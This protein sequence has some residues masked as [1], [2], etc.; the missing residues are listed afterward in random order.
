MW[1]TNSRKFLTKFPTPK[2]STP[3]MT[4]RPGY[5]TMEM[6][7]GSSAPH[8]ARTH[9]VPLFV[10]CLI[11]VETD[12]QGW[13]GIISI[14]RWNLRPVIFAVE[15]PAKRSRIFTDKLLWVCSDNTCPCPAFQLWWHFPSA[16][17]NDSKW[18]IWDSQSD[19]SEFL[20]SASGLLFRY[21]LIGNTDFPG[22]FWPLEW[23]WD[24]NRTFGAR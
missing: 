6:N 4:G 22:I 1:S 20:G 5:R 21:S 2:D 12:Y 16:G 9:C 18:R 23:F 15:R 24:P 19:F 8:L 10:H 11:R 13:A 17:E 3:N 7:G 14:V